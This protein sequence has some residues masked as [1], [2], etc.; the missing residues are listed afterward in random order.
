MDIE[1]AFFSGSYMPNSD[2]KE[3]LL[4]RPRTF[5]LHLPDL[6]GGLPKGDIRV[7]RAT[8]GNTG[9]FVSSYN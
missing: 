1:Q 5:P 7:I 6:A 3:L 8:A 9:S 4:K 2:S